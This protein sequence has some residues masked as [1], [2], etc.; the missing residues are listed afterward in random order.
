MKVLVRVL[1]GLVLVLVVAGVGVGFSLDSLVKAAVERGG[2]EALGVETK[3]ASADIGLF[4]GHFA[5]AGLEVSNPPG[6]AEPNFFALRST[7]LELPLSTLL[8]AS[9]TIPSLVIEGI[10]LDLERNASGTNYGTILKSLER[11]ESEP[12]PGS[13]PAP[14]EAGGKTFRLQRL[15]IRDVRATA[16]LL[17]AG[18]ELTKVSLAIPEIVVEDLDSEMSLAQLCALVVKT[19]VG[20][21]IQ[22]GSGVLPEELLADLRGRVKGLEGMARGALDEKL[23]A[24]EAQLSEQAKKLGPEAE[25]A[26]K[27]ASDKL[28]GKLDGLLKKKD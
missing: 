22:A 17:P 18:G 11:F 23:E 26:L 7:E 20:A 15:V 5:L 12:A 24:V 14:T 28:G 6:F 19:V 10:T 25:K 1:I 13:E 3:L 16:S 2:T 8:D 21:A 9:I 27:G 4:S